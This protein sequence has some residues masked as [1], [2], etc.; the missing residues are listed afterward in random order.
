MKT[1]VL[2]LGNPILSDDSVGIKIAQELQGSIHELG[3]IVAESSSSGLS[4]LELLID[5]DRV[6]IVD[7]IQTEEGKAGCIYHLGLSGLTES[8]HVTSCHGI[9]L[10]MAIRLGKQLGLKLPQQID[11]FAIE[12]ADVNTF[13][14]ELTPEVKKAVPLCLGMIAHALRVQG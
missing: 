9:N 5:Y 4:L 12:A 6:I 7:A 11:I 13:N 3:V 8:R 1:L 14:E 10:A 2:G